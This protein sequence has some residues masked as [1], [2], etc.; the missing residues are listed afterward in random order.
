MID[1]Q[2]ARLPETVEVNGSLFPVHTSFKYWLRFL[3]LIEDKKT[4]PGAFD[5]LYVEAKPENRMEGLAAL[6]KFC[7]PGELLP[8]VDGSGRGEK[9]VDYTVDADYIYAAFMEMYGIDLVESGMHWYKFQALFRG[10]HGTKLNEIIGY[11]LY[12]NTSGKRDNYVRHMEKLRSAW[13]LPEES[14]EN[15]EELKAFE[16]KLHPQQ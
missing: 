16:A 14:D 6:V 10:L 8:R 3:D 1:L 7:N 4:S 2:K 13:E 9:A 15:D 5:F 12:E 11:R